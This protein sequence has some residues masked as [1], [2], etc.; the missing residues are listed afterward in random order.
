MPYYS[1][2]SDAGYWMHSGNTASIYQEILADHYDETALRLAP[3]YSTY[4]CEY[5]CYLVFTERIVLIKNK[6]VDFVSPRI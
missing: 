3:R 2:Q 1:E 5:C 4:L 6:A